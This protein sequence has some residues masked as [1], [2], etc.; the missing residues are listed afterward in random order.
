MGVLMDFILFMGCNSAEF[1]WKNFTKVLLGV[2]IMFF[3]YLIKERGK[4]ERHSQTGRR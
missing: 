3:I 1:A 2:K 4:K